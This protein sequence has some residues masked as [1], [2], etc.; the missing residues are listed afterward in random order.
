M[1]TLLRI[2]IQSLLKLV[3][4]V[5]GMYGIA[6]IFYAVW[7]I[8]IRH[9]QVD[10]SYPLAP[11]FIYAI[12]GFGAILCAIT[13]WGHIA[14]EMSNIWCLYCYL[15]FIFLILILEGAITMDVI[16]NPNWEKDFPKDPSGNLIELKDFIKENIHFCKW[17]GLSILSVEGFCM[18]LAT[19]L[20]ALG[21]HQKDYESD[22]E[23]T[24]EGVP[25][26][27]H[28]SKHV[29]MRPLQSSILGSFEA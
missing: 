8:K 22:N 7:I 24:Q 16:L 28:Y 27:K 26:L 20:I 23:C 21:P 29:D 2:C 3:N 25:F 13:L 15:I 6:T 9:H 1:T 19:I 14:A 10:D 17:V 12:F 11:W 4:S 18:F 5:M